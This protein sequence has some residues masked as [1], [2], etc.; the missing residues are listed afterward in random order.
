MGVVGGLGPYAGL[1]LVRKVFAATPARRDQDHLPLA[2]VSV[3]HRVPDRTAFLLGHASENPGHAIADVVS[4]LVAAGAEVVGVP[5]N[6]AHAPAIFAPVVEAA[7]GR[8][9]LVHMVEEVAAEIRR[10]FPSAR[11]VGVLATTGTIA[12]GT[13]SQCLG[14]VG[15]DVV[16]PSEA[17]QE[18]EVHPAVYDPTFGIKAVSHPPDRRAVDGLRRALLHLTEHGAEVVVLACTEVPLALSNKDSTVPLVDATKVL[19]RSLVRRSLRLPDCTPLPATCRAVEV[20][21][22]TPDHDLDS[23]GDTETPVV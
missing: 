8:C 14:A 11:R 19:A 3:P 4:Q 13:Y 1:D 18:G 20:D 22:C 23:N 17:L 5:C 12:A 10:R 2:L 6:T 9:E 15:I 16:R 21:E 7:A